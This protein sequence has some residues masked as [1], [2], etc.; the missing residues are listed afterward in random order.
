MAGDTRIGYLSIDLYDEW[1][2]EIIFACR[3]CSK[4]TAEKGVSLFAPRLSALLDAASREGFSELVQL[5]SV[6]GSY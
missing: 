3:F 2:D 4:L 5:G 1:Y 6:E